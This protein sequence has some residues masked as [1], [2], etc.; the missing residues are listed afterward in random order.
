MRAARRLTPHQPTSPSSASIH[1]D[2]VMM[3]ASPD[4]AAGGAAAGGGG[5]KRG[6]K[7]GGRQEWDEGEITALKC[8]LAQYGV[9]RWADI[10][11]DGR[12]CDALAGRTNVDLKDKFRNLVGKEGDDQEK[13]LAQCAAAFRAWKRLGRKRLPTPAEIMAEGA[14]ELR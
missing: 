7:Q 13:V 5:R 4:G 11:K 14:R 2:D 3:M 1:S 8:G 12:L 10:K 9:G 6:R